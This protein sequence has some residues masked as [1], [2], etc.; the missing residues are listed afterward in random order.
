MLKRR[1]FELAEHVALREKLEQLNNNTF[2]ETTTIQQQKKIV[3]TIQNNNEE[4]ASSSAKIFS[5]I[6]QQKTTGVSTASNKQLELEA[7][8][9]SNLIDCIK[10]S[11]ISSI[12]E[13][14]KKE[15]NTKDSTISLNSSN[16]LLKNPIIDLHMEGLLPALPLLYP[17]CYNNNNNKVMLHC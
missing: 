17:Y 16:F 4:V 11:N 9:T 13:E 6:E 1:N 8:T 7:T 2:G 3:V 14:N 5:C 12:K 10:N 15:E